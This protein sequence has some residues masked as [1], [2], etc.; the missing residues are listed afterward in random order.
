MQTPSVE[1]AEAPGA[2]ESQSDTTG[3]DVQEHVPLSALANIVRSPGGTRSVSKGGRNHARTNTESLAAVLAH[4]AAN[5]KEQREKMTVRARECQCRFIG[6]L[7]VVE[8][9]HAE[10]ARKNI[11][12]PFLPIVYRKV[13][14]A[15]TATP[16]QAA[17][18]RGG[19]EGK[20]VLVRGD[21]IHACIVKHVLPFA[22][23]TY[24]SRIGHQLGGHLR[25]CQ[26]VDVF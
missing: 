16:Q 24:A 22:R 13:N 1:Y 25:G 8:A 23:R 10:L 7:R 20:S 18:Q 19:N 11:S 9:T 14:V 4:E 15:M 17:T 2:F 3:D 21:A 26:R 12:G 5:S 6:A